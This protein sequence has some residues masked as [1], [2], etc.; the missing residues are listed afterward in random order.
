MESRKGNCNGMVTK[1]GP[2]KEEVIT[3]VGHKN[4]VIIEMGRH[5]GKRTKEHAT[6]IGQYCSQQIHQY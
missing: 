1:R 5:V 6:M 4:V 3:L 2:K